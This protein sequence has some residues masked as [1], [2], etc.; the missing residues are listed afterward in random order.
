ME[1]MVHR[2][3]DK[4]RDLHWGWKIPFNGVLL[5]IIFLWGSIA[6]D[7]PKGCQTDLEDRCYIYT[8][9][10]IDGF[11]PKHV[12]VAVAAL[13]INILALTSP[14][15]QWILNSAIFMFLGQVSY[16]LYLIHILILHWLQR[17]TYEY[18]IGEG[19]EA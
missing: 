13:A 5:A 16:T 15:F 19:V 3:L 1:N 14:V 12:T 7:S 4:I 10:T 18:M 17:D 6:S 2:P 9:I 8:V 11:I